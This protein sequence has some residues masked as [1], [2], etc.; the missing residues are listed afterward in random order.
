MTCGRLWMLSLCVVALASGCK[1]SRF[2]NPF[3]LAG[4][5]TIDT[6]TQQT[7]Y[8]AYMLYCYA[9]HGEQ[10]DGRGPASAGMR[11]PPR[12]FQ[13]AKFKFA[14]VP[15][16]QL[17]VDEALDRTVRRGLHGTP[18][19]PWD[20]TDGERHALIQYIKTFKAPGAE[21]N[22]WQE[23]EVGPAIEI[24]PD[25]WKGKEAEAV[26]LGERVYHVSG[27][28]YAGCS[29]CH[30]GYAPFDT[31]ATMTQEITKEPVAGFR[32]DFYRTTPRESQY[33]IEVDDRGETV[34]P[35]MVMVP[36]FLF[37]KVKTVYP[38]GTQI[39]DG[40]MRL[41]EYSPDMQRTDL[42]RTIASGI[43]GAAMPTWKGALPEENL[44]ALTY[45]VQSLINKRGTPDGNKLRTDLLA[46]AAWQ[47]P[48]PQEP[49]KK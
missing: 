15:A 41:V 25:P 47:A 20:I 34:K 35:H 30:A 29:G 28:G 16:G 43:D 21:K 17:P 3:E 33:P 36:D 6:A 49:E 26:A 46:Q 5:K 13:Q 39:R 48:A 22:R 8:E 32:E 14:G 9:C 12:N 18:M 31:V 19:L 37:H 7:G 38:L 11:P 42:Y 10:G 27:E 44:W 45:Y 4:G 40:F 23:E 2:T 1:Q 24:S